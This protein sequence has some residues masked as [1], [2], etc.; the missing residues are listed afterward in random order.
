M[1][2]EFEGWAVNLKEGYVFPAI[3]SARGMGFLVILIVFRK[4]M[5]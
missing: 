3:V 1:N 2:G 4:G 5:F